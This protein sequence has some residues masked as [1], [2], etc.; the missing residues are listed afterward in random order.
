[1][2]SHGYIE[3]EADNVEDAK[4]LADSIESYDNFTTSEIVDWGWRGEPKEIE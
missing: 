2:T 4:I 3:V 1:M